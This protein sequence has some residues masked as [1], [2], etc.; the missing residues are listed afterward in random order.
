MEYYFV[1][2]L[3]REENGIQVDIRTN[4]YDPDDSVA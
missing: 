4:K 2:P 1:K 3:Q